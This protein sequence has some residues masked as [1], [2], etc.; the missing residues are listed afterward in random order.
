MNKQSQ[1]Q[2]KTENVPDREG[3]LGSWLEDLAQDSR[4]A[5]RMLRRSPG[6]SLVAV[7]TVALGIGAS[8]AVFTVINTF[9]LSSIPIPSTSNLVAVYAMPESADAHGN[10]PQPVSFPD[11]KEYRDRNKAFVEFAGY[12][13]PMPISFSEG[14]SPDRLFAELVTGNYFTTLGL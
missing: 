4:Y 10:T 7:L 13:S 12:S 11:L 14:K 3:S 5:L 9:F 2:L 6:F 8:T 1:Q